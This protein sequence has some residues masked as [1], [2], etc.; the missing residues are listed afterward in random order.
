[1]CDHN[2]D[3][4]S[5]HYLLS[6]FTCKTCVITIMVCSIIIVL[7]TSLVFTKQRCKKKK[8]HLTL[9]AIFKFITSYFG[10]T[11]LKIQMK[12]VKHSC[13]LHAYL[14][15]DAFCYFV[16]VIH[17]IGC[18]AFKSRCVLKITLTCIQTCQHDSILC[19][20]SFTLLMETRCV[21]HLTK[22]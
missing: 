16:T 17:R 8:M 6:C 15:F 22:C 18:F 13:I 21:R 2:H 12:D 1:M 5:H 3:L 4:D 7:L 20:N 11:M 9:N 19:V 10:H 14:W